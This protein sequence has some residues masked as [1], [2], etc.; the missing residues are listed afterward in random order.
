MA[1]LCYTW[2]TINMNKKPKI[3]APVRDEI[4]FTAAVAAGA[5][6]VYF[7]VGELNMRV[8]SK[9]IDMEELPRIVA[10]AHERGVEVFI[11]LNVIVYEHELERMREIIQSL[12]D[13]GVDA[14]ICW[15]LAVIKLCREM[16]MTFHISTQASIS[17]SSAG[18]FYEDLGARCIVLA[19]ECT[20]PQIKEIKSKMKTAKVEIFVHGAMCV[21]VSGR[22]FM[23]NFLECKSANRGEC[24]QPCRREYTVRDKES[25]HELDVSNGYVMSPK[26]LCTIEILDEIV[27]TGADYLKIEGRGRSPEYIQTTVACYRKAVNA[28]DTGEYT[29]ELKDELLEELKKVYNRGFSTGF[30][31]GRPAH[32]AW[33][34]VRNSQATE[35]KEYLGKVQNYYRKTNIAELKVLNGELNV[36]DVLQFQGPTTGVERM[37]VGSFESHPDQEVTVETSF[38]VRKSDEVYKIIES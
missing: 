34:R 6:A 31:F 13:A 5:D 10:R 28:I 8:S 11:T 4:S 25:G 23:S 2:P 17:N 30:M 7:G 1:F 32:E 19:R 3:L 29:D 38:I 18:A 35:K 24:F 33:S 26:D 20:L 16:G 22:C 14:V 21:S 37:I 12:K 9:G 15:D 27:E 36:G